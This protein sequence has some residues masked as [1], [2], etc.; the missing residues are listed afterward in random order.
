M[1]NYVCMNF[2][3]LCHSLRSVVVRAA[4]VVCLTRQRIFF[5]SKDCEIFSVLLSMCKIPTCESSFKMSRDLKKE[6]LITP[7]DD[8]KFKINVLLSFI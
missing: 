6:R 5:A 3:L 1:R 7:C 4:A 2:V 8:V